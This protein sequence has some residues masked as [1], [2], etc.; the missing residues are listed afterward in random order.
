MFSNN[1]SFNKGRKLPSVTRSCGMSSTR[2]GTR[3]GVRSSTRAGLGSLTPYYRAGVP[4]QAK[5]GT[6]S[7]LFLL[8][9]CYFLYFLLGDTGLILE[10][11]S[12]PLEMF[13]THLVFRPANRILVMTMSTI[14]MR[15]NRS[16]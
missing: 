7:L 10:F 6:P 2:F 15:H 8:H 5:T 11:Q 13:F 14:C 9:V 4:G 12:R 16:I 3:S 1:H